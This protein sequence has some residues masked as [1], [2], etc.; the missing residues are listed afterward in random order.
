MST[1]E[2]RDL[3]KEKDYMVER[4]EVRGGGWCLLSSA[5]VAVLVCSLL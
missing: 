4:R 1:R 3:E 2:M 5:D